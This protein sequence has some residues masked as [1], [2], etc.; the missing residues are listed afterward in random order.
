MEPQGGLCDPSVASKFMV[1]EAFRLA[2]S[3]RQLS[4]GRRPHGG[5]VLLLQHG[6]RGAAGPK[7][8][9]CIDFQHV[10]S[11]AA[12]VDVDAHTAQAPLHEA[13]DVYI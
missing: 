9:A 1:S 6:R 10:S 13:Q 11:Q 2:A 3:S 5:D 7:S 4:L 8:R 12:M